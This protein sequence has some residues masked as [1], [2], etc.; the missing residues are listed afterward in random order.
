M[1]KPSDLFKRTGTGAP[2]PP[3]AQSKNA[4]NLS[5]TAPAKA[6]EGESIAAKKP[7]KGHNIHAPARAQGGAGGSSARPKV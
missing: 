5:A 2:P 7:D 3:P 6:A 1:A 4:I